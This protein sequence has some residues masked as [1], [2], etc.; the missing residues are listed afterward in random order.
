[1]L[2]ANG[3]FTFV[4]PKGI[5]QCMPLRGGGGLRPIMYTYAKECC[6]SATLCCRGLPQSFFLLYN[7]KK[8]SGAF[9]ISLR[10]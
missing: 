7:Y 5:P 2:S 4:Y 9:G 1:M 6:V 3:S 8:V 10:L